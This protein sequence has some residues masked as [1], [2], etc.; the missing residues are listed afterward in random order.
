M[1]RRARLTD[2]QVEAEIAE[3][4]ENENVKLARLEE[5]IKNRRRQYLYVLRSYEKRG[6]ELR[7]NGVDEMNIKE[8][9]FE[10]GCGYEA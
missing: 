8:Y 9:L 4:L 3:L 10:E 5:R 7:R 6:A 1:E 2:E